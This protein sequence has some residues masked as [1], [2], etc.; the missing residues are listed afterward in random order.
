MNGRRREPTLTYREPSSAGIPVRKGGE[1]VK[2]AAFPSGQTYHL[3]VDPDE[4]IKAPSG[5]TLMSC[6]GG[7]IHWCRGRI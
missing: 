7:D 1:D 2:P 4:P 6:R 5:N 3:P